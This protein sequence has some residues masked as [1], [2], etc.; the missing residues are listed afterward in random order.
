MFAELL[1]RVDEGEG[2]STPL[3]VVLAIRSTD[4]DPEVEEPFRTWLT[5]SDVELMKLDPINDDAA[6]ELV[7]KVAVGG[8][9]PDAVVQFIVRH[10]HGVPLYA[11][12][13]EEHK[14]T[15][16]PSIDSS[17]FTN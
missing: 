11:A 13:F 17:C 15:K 2:P 3:V 4:L 16:Y 12:N 9:L 5:R 10:S 1:R 7:G 14:A 6:A 8:T